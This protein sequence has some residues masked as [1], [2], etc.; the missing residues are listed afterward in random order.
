MHRM[1]LLT[2]V[3]TATTAA[4]QTAPPAPPAP[5]A[6]P[7]PTDAP[8]PPAP[9]TGPAMPAI[10]PY[11]PSSPQSFGSA[12]T[13]PTSTTAT[14]TAEPTKPVSK[15]PKPGDFDAGGQLKLPSGPDG[16]G[17]FATYNW[18]GVDVKGKYYLAPTV[19]ANFLAPVAI[20]HPD[21]LMDGTQPKMFGG[22]R[23]YLE[24][25]LP[26]LPSLPG[27]PKN[28]T[29][30]GIGLT[31]GYMHDGAML[32]SDKD[33][34]LFVGNFHPGFKGELITKVKLSSLVDFS[35]VPAWVFQGGEMESHAAVQVPMSL[36]LK[37]GDL[38]QTAADVGVFT[39][40]HYHFSGDSGGR[41]YAGGSLTVKIWKLQAHAGLGVASLL[42]G[43]LYPTIGDSVYVDLNVKYVK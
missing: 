37:L 16:D 24:A 9:P 20:H 38:V 42:T 39:G 18:I 8:P 3:F 22:F 25:K 6:P 4:A 32:L 1:C 27:V 43:G 34:P 5:Q 41:I 10:A 7:A 28:E 2:I 21:V 19:T 12:P 14:A 17:K 30:L 11:T 33:Y 29:E 40:D 35:L 13:S 36:I 26:K 15:E 31:F 23:A